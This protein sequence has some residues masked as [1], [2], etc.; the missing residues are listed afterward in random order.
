MCARWATRRHR[1]RRRG[2]SPAHAGAPRPATDAETIAWTLAREY[3]DASICA[4]GAVSPLAVTSY[5]LAKRSHAPGLTLITTAGGYVDVA[6]RPML[7]GLGE[8][9]DF[10]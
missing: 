2:R 6:W 4:A 3:D 10:A 7:L 1:R 8:A 5:L 9:I